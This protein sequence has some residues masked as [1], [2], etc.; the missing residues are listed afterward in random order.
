MCF[1]YF[2]WQGGK[3][4]ILHKETMIK[5]WEHKTVKWHIFIY[6]Y[7]TG[8]LDGAQLSDIVLQNGFQSSVYYL[9]WCLIVLGNFTSQFRD[10]QLEACMSFLIFPSPLIRMKFIVIYYHFVWVKPAMALLDYFQSSL[11]KPATLCE[12][13]AILLSLAGSL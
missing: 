7:V 11:I 1:L 12:K 2:S 13:V 8:H 4:E 10:Y 3:A 6:V 9:F 5:I